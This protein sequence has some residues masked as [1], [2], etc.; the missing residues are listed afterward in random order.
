MGVVDL[1]VL[2]D[3]R[4]TIKKLEKENG[5]GFTFK[6]DLGTW[7]TGLEF[8]E[9]GYYHPPKSNSWEEVAE[10][11][12]EIKCPDLLDFEHRIILEYEEEPTAGKSSGKLGKKGHTEESEKDTNRDRLYRIGGFRVFK[13]WQSEYKKLKTN[14]SYEW[15]S[16]EKQKEFEK[17]LWK[18]LCDCYTNREIK[19]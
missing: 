11:E 4:Q 5:W 10:N 12:N 18:F 6:I 17:K 14:G 15:E 19:N 9:M 2:D 1:V 7:E 13:V 8:W 16:K 3:I